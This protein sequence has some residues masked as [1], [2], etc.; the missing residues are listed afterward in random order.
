MSTARHDV[1]QYGLRIED[2]AAATGA[3]VRNIRVYQEKGLLPPP[4]RK[5]RTALY[6]PDHQRRLQ[7]VLRLLDRGYTFATIDE[8]FTAD[9]LGLSLS[10]LIAAENSRVLRRTPSRRRPYLLSEAHALVGYRFSEHLLKAGNDIGVA[11][12]PDP[13]AAVL[14]D[15]LLYEL[16]RELVQLGLDEDDIAKVAELVFEGQERAAQ[17]FEVVLQRLR[18]RGY[19]NARA[20]SRAAELVDH[21]GRAVR[22]LFQN[23]ARRRI[24]EYSTDPSDS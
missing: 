15:T 1:D 10:E 23:A 16:L 2:L 13:D 22:T 3:T 7:V 14:S 9:R 18:E 4:V 8:L 17:G 12:G 11:D 21:A 24:T 5:G 6:G 20:V 19:D